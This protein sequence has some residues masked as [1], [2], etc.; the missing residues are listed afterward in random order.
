V[1]DELE[2]RGLTKREPAPNDRRS[3]LLS[4]TPAGEA[5]LHRLIALADEHE[6]RVLSGISAKDREQLLK[7]LAQLCRVPCAA[8]S[9]QDH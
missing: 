8:S 6:E 3:R 9:D 2:R 7:V 5:Q 4:L 1:L